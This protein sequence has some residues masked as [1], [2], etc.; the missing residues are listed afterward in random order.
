VT[1]V[2]TEIRVVGANCPWCLNETLERLRDQPGVVDAHAS[3]SDQCLRIEHD[4]L[5]VDELVMLVRRHLHGAELSSLEPVMVE[6]DAQEAA[7]HCHHGA[8]RPA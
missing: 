7:L 1:P 8:A 3:M 4:G 2:T 5:A 6:V